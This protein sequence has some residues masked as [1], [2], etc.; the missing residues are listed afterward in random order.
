MRIIDLT[1]TLRTGFPVFPA[2]PVPVV[3]AWTS[4]KEHGFYSNLL[5]IIEHV[6]THVDAPAHFI[7]GGR[8]IDE[9]L[10]DRFMGKGVVIDVTHLGPKE[11]ITKDIIKGILS[12]YGI[13]S[14]KGWVVLFYT[15]HDSKLGTPE[16]FNHPGLDGSGAKYLLDLGVNAVGIDAPSIDHEPYPAHK[17][18][19]GNGVPIYE[20]LTNLKELVDKPRFRFIGLPLKILRGSASPVRAIAIIEE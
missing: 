5:I 14:L 20:N 9:V 17:L 6:G 10:I 19:L 3:H 13:E 11:P 16:W 8:T 1:M 18:L 2:Y 15:G 7:E 4:V 12:K